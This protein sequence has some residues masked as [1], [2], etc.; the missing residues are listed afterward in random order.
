MP[1]LS[2]HDLRFALLV[3][4]MSFGRRRGPRGRRSR[5]SPEEE[6]VMDPKER[7]V[8]SEANQ[9]RVRAG[10]TGHGV[11]YVLIFGTALVIVLF[12]AVA[13]FVKS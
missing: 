7:P 3:D 8:V 10:V 13:A 1:S 12:I 9:E 5:L 4:I 6:A 11:R 2:E